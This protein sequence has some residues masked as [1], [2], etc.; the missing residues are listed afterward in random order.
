VPD[1]EMLMSAS[2]FPLWAAAAAVAALVV[3]VVSAVVVRLIGANGMVKL[4]GRVIVLAAVVAAGWFLAERAGQFER[5]SS[6]RALDQRSVSL[7]AQ[8]IA[9]GSPL[10]CLDA[11]AGETI[12]T[13]C[14]QAVFAGPSSIAA[15]VSYT[16]ARL[17]LLADA[18]DYVKKSDRDYDAVLMPIRTALESDRFGIVAHVL[19]LRDSCTELQCDAFALLRDT[20]RVQANLKERTFDGFVGRHSTDWAGKA[21]ASPSSAETGSFAPASVAA[22]VSPLSPRFDFPSAASIPPVS[23]MSPEPGQAPAAAPSQARPAAA[24]TPTPPRRP[25]APARATPP[26]QGQNA[27]VQIAPPVAAGDTDGKSLR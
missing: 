20:S 9:P 14:E 17:A 19:S 2:S 26:R 8:A 16:A 3:V 18:A 1:L 6:R 4:T 10:A 7:T 13:A 11:L 15:A 5:T 24:T 12:E 23:I 25:A 27:P 21:G 22:P